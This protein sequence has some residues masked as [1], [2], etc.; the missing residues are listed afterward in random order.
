[1]IICLKGTP[2]SSCLRTAVNEQQ[3]SLFHDI[4][5]MQTNVCPVVFF[6]PHHITAHHSTCACLCPH[7]N[8]S[9]LPPQIPNSCQRNEHTPASAQLE[10]TTQKATIV[11]HGSSTNLIVMFGCIGSHVVCCCCS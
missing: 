11:L 4:D 9:A 7:D 3:S 10:S 8:I 5:V 1:M 6:F 2:N